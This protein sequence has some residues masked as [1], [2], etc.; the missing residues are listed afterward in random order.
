MKRILTTDWHASRIFRVVTGLAAV[1]YALVKQDSLLGIA[2]AMLLI[3][4]L[5]NT[6]CGAAGGC[7]VPVR[8]SQIKDS[9][10]VEKVN[11]V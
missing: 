1:I 5:S 9:A 6:G 4:G 7:Q 10:Q 11:R 3:M 8:K 2:G